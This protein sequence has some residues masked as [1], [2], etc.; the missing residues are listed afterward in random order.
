MPSLR[1]PLSRIICLVALGA[2]G[3]MS[4]RAYAETVLVDGG[5]F[6]IDETAD[7]LDNY[8]VINGGK[9]SANGAVLTSVYTTNSEVIL[10]GSTINS[11]GFTPAFRSENTIGTINNSFINSESL[12]LKV[13]SSALG[14]SHITV[15]DST[16]TAVE[17]AATIDSQSRLD[18]VNTTLVATGGNG[19]A[20]EVF[21]GEFK[22]TNS[23][24]TGALN[25]IQVIDVYN[26]VD[27]LVTLDGTSVVGQGGSAII[28]DN[29]GLGTQNAQI[30]VLNGSTLS[31]A[32]GILLEVVDTA[33][34]TLTVGN[35]HLV[36]DV[37]A[38]Q[39]ATAR[40]I[41]DDQATLTG[42]LDNISSLAIN[43]Q[44]QW[45]MVENGTV[46]DLSMNGGSIKFGEPGDY[47]TLSVG[48]LSGNGSFNMA[49]DFSTGDTDFLD[50]TGT[51]TGN[52][53]LLVSSSGADPLTPDKLYLVHTAAGDA[54][55]SLVNDRVDV[56]AYSYELASTV[57][58]G[59]TDWYLNPESKVISPGTESVMALFNAAPT[60]WYGELTTLRSRMGEVRMDGGQPGM[61]VRAYGNKYAVSAASGL[62][63]TQNQQGLSFGA[64]TRLPVGDGQWLVGLLAGYSKSDLDMAR[65]TT[66]TVD[67]YYAGAYTTWLDAQTG[68]YFDGV[69]KVNRFQNKSTVSL[70]D[71]TTSKGSYN[72]YGVGVSAEVGR[73]IKLDD[74]YFVE[75]YAQLASVAVQGKNYELDNGM[76]AEGDRT[77]SLLA[78]VGSTVGRNF[79]LADGKV[80]Q[81]YV[82][83]AY[84]H[85]FVKTNEVRVNDNVFNNDLSGSRGE[86][87]AGLSV[88]MSDKLSVHVDVDYSNGDSIEQPWGAALGVRYSW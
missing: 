22:A 31:G 8:R 13:A 26:V 28:V 87:G 14:G 20:L 71:N 11:V 6:V 63:Y 45:I 69:V 2:T 80:V 50:V 55:F 67:S 82:R 12:G 64:D 75:P 16:V 85:E 77:R 10:N 21:D 23:S 65:G 44:A 43:N 29:Y 37:V 38:A 83:A 49:S 32:N 81:P 18:I 33:T 76:Q 35:S 72:N 73:H 9:L 88:S 54:Q 84:V 47:Y 66:G 4:Q 57:T 56:G 78:K 7:P 15:L 51:A 46:A 24:I 53:E 3:L 27:A 62:G 17:R 74:G 42:R 19:I 41:L 40:V 68:Y 86:L 70:S 48:N 60:V 25:G 30:N 34:A 58:G 52:H 79:T 5:E 59:E 61:W 39:G 1:T 36:G